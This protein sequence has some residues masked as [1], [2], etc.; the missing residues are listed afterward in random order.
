MK[1]RALA[2]AALLSGCNQAVPTYSASSGSLALSN[3]DGLLYAAD[4]DSNSLF[5]LDAK[6]EELVAKVDV[7]TQPEKVI[8]AKDDTIFV[9]NRMSR[10]I[11]VIHRGEWKEATRLATAVEP[12]GMAIDGNTLYVVNA[13]M[14]DDAQVGSLMAFDIASLS[15]K[16]EIPVGHEPRAVAIVGGKAMVSL[17]KDSAG[18][19]GADVTTVDL[20]KQQVVVAKTDLYERL[21]KSAITGVSNNGGGAQPEPFPTKDGLGGFRVAQF[22]PRGIESLTVSP[23]GKQVFA[24]TLLSSDTVLPSTQFTQGTIDPGF[25]SGGGDGYGGGSCGAGAVASPA[26]VTFDGEGKSV[27]EDVSGCEGQRVEGAPAQIITSGNP[28]MPIQGPSA[29]VVDP[30]GAFLFVVGRESNNVAIM[31]TNSAT[32]NDPNNQNVG[33]SFAGAPEARDS[34]GIGFFDGSA[35]SVH[36]T[37]MV[38]SGPSGIALSHDGQV[39]WVHNAFDHSISR[40]ERKNGIVQQVRSTQFTSD[41]LPQDVV[42]GRKLFFSASDSRMSS[43]STGISCASCH[44]EGREDGHVWNFTDG[45]RQTPSLTGRM[46]SKTAPFHWNGEFDG[47]TQFMSQ[48]VNHRM[49]GAGV[50]P[51]ME[52]QIA[53]FI[54]SQPAADNPHKTELR[55]AAAERGAGVF[56]KAQCNSCHRGETLTDNSFVDVGTYVKDTTFSLVVDDVTRFAKGGLN[57]PSLLGIAR[58][59]PYLHDGSVMTLKERITKGKNADLHGKTAQ[60]SDAEVDDLVEYLKT[61]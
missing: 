55:S 47:L 10:S 4:S 22:H 50:S 38:G 29:T 30:T 13:T 26:I 17:Y 58:T 3:D 23:D 5:V 59:A 31:P 1:I 16:F 25:P 7:G 45:P 35:G 9:A 6:T 42:A 28:T 57:T 8:V 18:G 53:A 2:V 41:V 40:L 24:A 52:K 36:T 37:V 19:K 32:A 60:L 44:L 11:S 15:K 21:N 33:S 61:L 56:N 39:A 14:L 49:G 20:A 34:A 12:T 54:D 51:A 46:L 27:A 43:Q 48:T